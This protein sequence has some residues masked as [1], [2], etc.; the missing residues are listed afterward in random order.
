MVP[1]GPASAKGLTRSGLAGTAGRTARRAGQ[2]V[3]GTAG[4]GPPRC[5]HP[6]SGAEGKKTWDWTGHGDGQENPGCSLPCFLHSL[7]DGVNSKGDNR[8]HLR[9][10][11]RP[12]EAG[13]GLESTRGDWKERPERTQGCRHQGR[14][15]EKI[16]HWP[17]GPVGKL[18]Q[19]RDSD[20]HS[21]ALSPGF[22]PPGHCHVRGGG[23]E[24]R[25]GMGSERDLCWMPVTARPF[26][27][28]HP[29]CHPKPTCPWNERI[30]SVPEGPGS[31]VG[32]EPRGQ[33]VEKG[34]RIFEGVEDDGEKRGPPERAGLGRRTKE[35]GQSGERP[36]CGVGAG[37]GTVGATAPPQ[38]LPPP[39]FHD[40]ET[41]FKSGLP[42]PGG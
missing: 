5:P 25:R 21:V 32:G 39:P 34:G 3:P 37:G 19:R 29:R 16:Q 24:A 10:R 11:L 42:A 6:D 36:S 27:V 1:A 31:L 8:N 23:R 35:L 7:C 40:L 14:D 41:T 26:Q 30:P 9:G 33:A 12:T 4:A 13:G 15:G 2:R 22:P 28:S 18:R 20:W 38:P 17:C